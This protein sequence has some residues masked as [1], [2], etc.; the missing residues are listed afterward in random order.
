MTAAYITAAYCSGELN[1]HRIKA[2]LSDIQQ[3]GLTTVILFALHIGG[4][5]EWGNFTFNEPR[6]LFVSQRVFNPAKDSAIRD[7]RQSIVELKQHG[8]VVKIFFS[9]GG[10]NTKDFTAIQQMLKAKQANLLRTNFN[11]LRQAFTVDRDVCV[12]DGFDLDKENED[13]DE[14]TIVSFSEILFDLGFEVTFCPYTEPTWW[15]SCM[16][17]LWDQNHK[18]SWW[19][20]MCYAGGVPNRNDLADWI[21]KIAAVVGKDNKPASYLAPGL[22]VKTK[23]DYANGQCPTGPDS[24]ESTFT[25]WKD[26]GLRGGFLWSYDDIVKSSGTGLCKGQADDLKAYVAALRAGSPLGESPGD[27]PRR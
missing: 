6:W 13:I 3:S 10:W 20:L 4:E 8:S 21:D 9:I 23:P 1:P 25:N 12:I 24:I 7:W 22:A 2:H 16:K 14:D 27:R 26:L 17:K 11:A 15:Q 5:G 19:N 18:V